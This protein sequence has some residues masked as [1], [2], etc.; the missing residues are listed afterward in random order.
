M[1]GQNSVFHNTPKVTEASP[2]SPSMPPHHV[3]LSPPCAPAQ[4]LG[5][6]EGAIFALGVSGKWE[7]AMSLLDDIETRGLVPDE[8]VYAEVVVAC[9]KVRRPDAAAALVLVKSGDVILKTFYCSA[10]RG[11]GPCVFVHSERRR[12]KMWR[13]PTEHTICSG[14]TPLGTGGSI[15]LARKQTTYRLTQKRGSHMPFS[16]QAFFLASCL[17]GDVVLRQTTRRQIVTCFKRSRFQWCDQLAMGRGEEGASTSSRLVAH[18][19]TAA[20]A[21]CTFLFFHGLSEWKG[22]Q[23]DQHA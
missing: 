17:W 11:V 10:M 13:S 21:T 5:V 20:T 22:R 16:K 8:G 1:W 9:G 15:G 23:G 18:L 3:L 12:E 6:Y 7:K 14:E 19:A 4:S 2:L